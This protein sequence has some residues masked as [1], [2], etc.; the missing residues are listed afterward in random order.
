M[1]VEP[2]L[3]L[4]T[5]HWSLMSFYS[6]SSHSDGIK[7][8][9][10]QHF[11]GLID[12]APWTHVFMTWPLWPYWDPVDTLFFCQC[13]AWQHTCPLICFSDRF[14]GSRWYPILLSRKWGRLQTHQRGRS[15]LD[16]LTFHLQ[17]EPQL[18]VKGRLLFPGMFVPTQRTEGISTSD[19][20][21]RI[22]RDYDV[23]ARRNLQRGYTAKELNVSYIN[24]R[25]PLCCRGF[26]SGNRVQP[27]ALGSKRTLRPFEPVQRQTS[28]RVLFPSVLHVSTSGEEVSATEPSR[29]H[30]GEGSNRWGEEQTLCLPC[31]GEESRPHPEMGGKISR[32]HR[33]LPGTLRPR[34]DMGKKSDVF[35]FQS[36]MRVLLLH[37]CFLKHRNK[38]FRSAAV[39]CCPTPCLPENL[40]A[41]VLLV[42][43][44]RCAPPP[45]RHPRPAGTTPGPR[46]R[47]PP[48]EP[49][50]PSAA[51]AKAM[52]TRSRRARGS[53]AV[54]CQGTPH[55]KHTLLQTPTGDGTPQRRCTS[56]ASTAIRGHVVLSCRAKKPSRS[57][58]CGDQADDEDK[59]LS[60]CAGL[61]TTNRDAAYVTASVC[62]VLF[63][64]MTS[65][66]VWTKP[67]WTCGTE[68]PAARL[69]QR[70]SQLAPVCTISAWSITDFTV[71]WRTRNTQIKSTHDLL[72]H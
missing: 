56:A 2:H 10:Y 12:K 23:Y 3:P 60:G 14:C 47:P 11:E 15:E 8:S 40:P 19:I 68:I 63:L 26:I 45:L 37:P 57:L 43:C 55:R 44:P 54:H 38:C 49:R 50:P 29:P 41:T 65:L 71:C 59:D 70:R 13:C 61:S 72:K 27:V 28:K 18:V 53:P 69:E 66:L 32:V 1:W 33:E 25:P 9:S 21:T 34:W 17:N 42:N 24:V 22:V 64:L 31:G 7:Q 52:K 16:F 20:I 6:P 48:K 67:H 4:W 35:Y 51:W 30:E 58:L 5:G 62:P 39:G 36:V 46:P